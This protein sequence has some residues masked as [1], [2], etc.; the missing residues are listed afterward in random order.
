MVISFYTII[1]QCVL[2][3]DSCQM[4]VQKG[5]P[6]PQE[7]PVLTYGRNST[8]ILFLVKK[9]LLILVSD[10]RRIKF[11]TGKDLLQKFS[12]INKMLC[13]LSLQSLYIFKLLP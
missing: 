1:E 6:E 13:F 3:R 7:N 5:E 10:I 8:S 9:E 2:C 11:H 4:S 12:G